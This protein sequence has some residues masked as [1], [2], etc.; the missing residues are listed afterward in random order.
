MAS[1]FS[2]IGRISYRVSLLASCLA[3]RRSSSVTLRSLHD[4]P[5]SLRVTNGGGKGASQ[6][7]R[8]YLVLHG[9]LD[10]AEAAIQVDLLV[11]VLGRDGM[12][13]LDGVRH[14]WRRVADRA[15][16]EDVSRSVEVARALG[17]PG[18]AA[19]DV[20]LI[21]KPYPVDGTGLSRAPHSEW[22]SGKGRSGYAVIKLGKKH[23]M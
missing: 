1:T 9:K 19:R 20:L 6:N 7:A 13:G 2:S 21:L 3:S 22:R 8:L 4:S 11:H 5:V 15:E 18:R 10:I 23:A 17:R 14:G 12:L 16:C